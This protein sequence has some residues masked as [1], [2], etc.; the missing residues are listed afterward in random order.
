MSSVWSGPCCGR[1]KALSVSFTYMKK[2]LFV[3]LLLCMPAVAL[4]AQFY[5]GDQASVPGAVNDDVYVGGGSVM[6]AGAVT[7]DLYAGG[8]TVIVSGPVSQD[9]VV[10]GGTVTVLNSVGDDLRL[11]GGNLTVQ[12][13]VGDD[14]L[15]GGGQVLVTGGRIGGDATIGAGVLRLESPVG[16]SAKLGGGDVYINTAIA[17]SV[18]IDA[19]KVTLGSNAV[20]A[21][22]LTYRSP[23]ELVLEDGARVL[24]DT[25]YEPREAREGAAA[26]AAFFSFATVVGFLMLLAA[27]L[28]LGLFFRRFSTDLVVGAYERPFVE[29]ARGFVFL[30]VAPV[31]AVILLISVIGVPLGLLAL[32][33]YVATIIFSWLL[34]PVLLGSFVWKWVTKGEYV[35]SW[36]SITVG[37]ILFSLLS[38]IP[39]VGWLA[40]FVLVLMALGSSLRIRWSVA[41]QWG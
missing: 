16:G 37:V 32:V 24:G 29:L 6:S 38:L 31:A 20:I 15:I 12:G 1:M 10:G 5:G 18:T 36:Q 34:S 17:G 26:K 21:G 7:G 23:N 35:V 28:V 2:V 22:D 13:D 30:I 11:G 19:D 8:G 3:A 41:Q 39:I 14:V 27:S 9:L 4:G 25:N 40:E 33:G